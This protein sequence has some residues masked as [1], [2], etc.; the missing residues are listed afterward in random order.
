VAVVAE[1]PQKQLE[2]EAR[3]RPRAGIAAMVVV[4][5]AIAQFWINVNLYKDAPNPSGIETLQRALKPGPVADLPSL[6]IPR[7]QYLDDRL[8]LQL[9]IGVLGLI[10]GIATAWVIGF[11]AVAARARRPQTGRW[12]IYLAIA[13]GVLTG[14]YAMLNSIGEITH[15]RSAL[16]GGRTVADVAKGDGLLV[17]SRSLGFFAL[18]ASLFAFI[19]VSVNAMR[20]GLLTRFLGIIGIGCGVF[21]LLSPLLSVLLQVIFLT[22][23]GLILLGYWMGGV[24]PAWETGRAELLPSRQSPQRRG[25]PEPAPEAAAPEATP[26][27]PAGTRGKRKKRH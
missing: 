25:V 8:V 15:A 3:Q 6:L 23:V 19:M 21:I 22:A 20:V 18:L 17:F 12:L 4:A 7:M 16:D 5:T 11:L 9:L 14:I 27:R 10:G 26:A 1:D 2:W 24:P 13:G